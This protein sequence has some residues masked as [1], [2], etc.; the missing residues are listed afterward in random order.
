MTRNRIVVTKKALEENR[1]ADWNAFVDLLAMTDYDALMPSQRPA[2]LVFW[3]ES[4]VQNGG[5]LQYFH[6][7]GHER[8]EETIRALDTLGADTQA[9]ILKQALAKWKSTARRPPADVQEYSAIALQGEFD[10]LDDAFYGCPVQ[11]TELLE[12][13]FAEHEADFIVRE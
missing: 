8:G 12:R 10:D 5:H 13:H 3:Y 1:Y 4:E 6:N 11:L 9:G 7:R 2:H